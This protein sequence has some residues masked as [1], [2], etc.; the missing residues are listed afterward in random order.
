MYVLSPD[1]YCE[2]VLIRVLM[3]GDSLSGRVFT[4][5]IA[6]NCCTARENSLYHK[7]GKLA[8]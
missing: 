3:A 2:C 1:R 4:A 5:G 7:K 8:G 6:I